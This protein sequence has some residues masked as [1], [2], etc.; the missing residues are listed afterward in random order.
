MAIGC[1]NVPMNSKIENDIVELKNK[2]L[3]IEA[4]LDKKSNTSDVAVKSMMDTNIQL[5]DAKDAN[6][7]LHYSDVNLLKPSITSATTQNGITVTPNSDGSFTVTGTCT[8]SNTTYFDIGTFSG[9]PYGEKFYFNAN[10]GNIDWGAYMHLTGTYSYGTDGSYSCKN[11]STERVSLAIRVGYTVD[12]TFYPMISLRN[13]NACV[14]YSGYTITACG[15]NLVDV[16]EISTW[17]ILTTSTQKRSN[18]KILKLKPNTKYTISQL[19]NRESNYSWLYIMS[20]RNTDSSV[21]W[22]LTTLNGCLVDSPRTITSDS[23]GWVT[24][25][26]Y[27]TITSDV[28]IQL[29]EGDTATNYEPFIGKKVIVDQNTTFPVTGLESYS[30]LTNIYNRYGATMEVCYATNESGQTILDSIA[31]INNKTG[32]TDISTIGDGTITGAIKTL[33]EKIDAL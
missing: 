24:V 15:K 14:P 26:S 9:I 2:D 13:T 3:E 12:K 19:S 21:N 4:I 7:L 23:E 16:S 10:A 1:M 17:D 27:N 28:Q 20:G 18:Q 8:S 11:V 6:M 29:E 22:S 31:N 33:Q 25:G 32:S 30:E 5:T